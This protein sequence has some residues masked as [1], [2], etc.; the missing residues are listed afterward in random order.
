MS[1]IISKTFKKKR[2]SYILTEYG[3]KGE[4]Q[5]KRV[6][7]RSERENKCATT[8]RPTAGVSSEGPYVHSSHSV[9]TPER[10]TRTKKGYGERR[11][12]LEGA[13]KEIRNR[14]QIV[15]VESC[16][17]TTTCCAV[18]HKSDI[19]DVVVCTD[20]GPATQYCI[21]CSRKI[22]TFVCF[23]KPKLWKV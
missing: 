19:V 12:K 5:S 7:L 11:T 16:A 4:R 20:C 21:E 14:L 2:V 8:G 23:H 22:H 17:P 1:G 6:Y 10:E 9:T 18:C 13:W 3:K 15:Y